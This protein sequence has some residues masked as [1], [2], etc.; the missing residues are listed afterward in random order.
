MA[1]AVVGVDI[2]IDLPVDVRLLPGV[3]EDGQDVRRVGRVEPERLNLLV[4]LGVGVRGRGPG[5]L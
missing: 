4:W 5:A 2:L 3:D 1:T